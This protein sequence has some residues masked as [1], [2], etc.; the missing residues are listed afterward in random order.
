MG[1]PAAPR[2]MIVNPAEIRSD[3]G[4]QT[5]ESGAAPTHHIWPGPPTT[6]IMYLTKMGG[7]SHP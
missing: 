6:C 7:A 5:P 2:D 4:Y 1:A 3:L